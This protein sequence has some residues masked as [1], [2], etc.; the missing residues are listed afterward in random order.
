MDNFN[1]AF[2]DHIMLP[3]ADVDIEA[4][5]TLAE[6][7][8]RADIA[9]CMRDALQLERDLYAQAAT[10]CNCEICQKRVQD[11]M[12]RHVAEHERKVFIFKAGHAHTR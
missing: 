6:I 11:E 8:G 4:L 3:I 9:D 10:P 5:A 7:R 12:E 2:G 1:A